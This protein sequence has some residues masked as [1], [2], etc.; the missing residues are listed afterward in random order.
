[1]TNCASTTTSTRDEYTLPERVKAQHILFKTQGKTPEEI[2]KIKEKARGVLE[3]AKKG[4]DFGALAK[5]FSEDSDRFD[6]RRSRRF[7]PR[8]DGAGI[9]ARR[10]QPRRRRHQRSGPD[11]NSEFTSSK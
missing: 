9:R 7:R 11:R 5:Q 2:E 1:M 3:R 8:P 4:E 6:R 10:I